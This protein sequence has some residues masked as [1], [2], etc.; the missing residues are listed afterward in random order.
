MIEH[1]ILELVLKSATQEDLEQMIERIVVVCPNLFIV[2]RGMRWAL[3]EADR[4]EV[5]KL[6][7]E[8]IAP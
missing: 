4:R 2:A 1:E 6:L 7:T 8:E 5:A 3:D